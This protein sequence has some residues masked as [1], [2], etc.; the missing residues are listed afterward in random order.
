MVPDN[1]DVW[2]PFNPK[3]DPLADFKTMNRAMTEEP[4]N[5]DQKPLLKFF[6]AVGL[7]P[8]QDVAKM[9]EATKR[10]LARA[11]KGGKELLRQIML[12]GWT[13]KVVNCW[14]YPPPTYGRAGLADDFVTRG[15][16]QCL[17]GI[18]AKPCL[19]WSGIAGGGKIL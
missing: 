11:T 6:A 13:S 2:P 3:S 14:K 7:G 17:G 15:A 12:G 9:D 8:D 19:E 18:I 16:L 5:A 4:P 10:G 1:R